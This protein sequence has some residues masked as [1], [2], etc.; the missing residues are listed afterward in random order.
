MPVE[1]TILT[2]AVSLPGPVAAGAPFWLLTLRDLTEAHKLEQM[3][4]DFVANA[5][6][7]LRTPLASLLGFIE[8]LR[9]SAR[10]DAGARERFLA[11]M[12][13]EG[14]RMKRLIDDLLSLSRIEMRQH[15]RPT[16]PVDLVE[17]LSH[18]VSSATP[19]AAQAKVAISLELPAG[20]LETLGDHDELVQLFGNLLQNAVKYG[21]SGGIA[22]IVGSR[23][24]QR[25]IEVAVIDDGPGIAPQHLPRLTERFY[26]V[27]TAASRI[28]GGTGLGLAIVKHLVQR[29]R[30]ELM[31]KSEF[32]K[33]ATFAV[34]LEAY[35]SP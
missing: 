30:G 7:E 26:R 32:G 33:G 24:G 2:T 22:R 14:G 29:H 13:I 35:E 18:V 19:A 11:I 16:T 28:A 21:R 5:S 23:M 12:A 20:R 31:I 27:D 25:T 15:M 10:D 17:V 1:R 4:A 9:G 3:R 34:V 8:T 6:H